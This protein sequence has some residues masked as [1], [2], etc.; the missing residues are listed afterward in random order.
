MY[1]VPPCTPLVISMWRA[2][3]SLS[4]TP[5]MH[6]RCEAGMKQSCVNLEADVYPGCKL[7]C[8][9]HILCT[10]CHYEEFEL[11]YW[12]IAPPL[13]DTERLVWTRWE[14]MQTRV[15]Q[16]KE[17]IRNN[18][19]KPGNFCLLPLLQLCFWQFSLSV[20]SVALARGRPVWSWPQVP[21]SL[22]HGGSHL[23]LSPHLTCSSLDKTGKTEH[24][25]VLN[26]SDESIGTKLL[27][28]ECLYILLYI[29]PFSRKSS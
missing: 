14:K 22:G 25:A 2:F 4:K 6:C 9:H 8:L 11:R 10:V 26:Y 24:S 15:E 20:F 19:N 12:N 29:L 7:R 5:S 27:A 28:Q 17:I 3:A 21:H 23:P 16:R 18:K 13:A 1:M